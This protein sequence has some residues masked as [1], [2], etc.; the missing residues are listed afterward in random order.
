MITLLIIIIFIGSYIAYNASKQNMQHS[1]SIIESWSKTYYKQAKIISIILFLLALVLAVL[2]F[3]YSSG[4]LFW[5]F[6]LMLFMGLVITI[7]PLK[8]IKYTH[9]TV[10]F[11][12]ILIIEYIF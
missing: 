8:I 11:L 4:V 12:L 2:K 6:L 10:F 9:L 1:K 5:L 3:G 7:A